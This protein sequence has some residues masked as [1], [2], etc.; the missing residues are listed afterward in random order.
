MNSLYP[1][2]MR[3]FTLNALYTLFCILSAKKVESFSVLHVEKLLHL[4]LYGTFLYVY[5]FYRFLICLQINF[6]VT[7]HISEQWSAI[8][9]LN[10]AKYSLNAILIT[11]KNIINIPTWGQ[12]QCQV[13]H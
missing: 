13:Y 2:E 3:P 10:V 6:K 7:F 9:G 4:G 5:I 11:I 8:C 1:D 12:K